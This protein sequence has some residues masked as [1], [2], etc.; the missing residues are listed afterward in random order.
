MGK[1][2]GFHLHPGELAGAADGKEYA[3]LILRSR[4]THAHG[5]Q[6]GREGAGVDGHERI[7][8][9]SQRLGDG[10]NV[11]V[12]HGIAGRHAAALG[13]QGLNAAAHGLRSGQYGFKGYETALQRALL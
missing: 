5:R 7:G 12:G 9:F 6:F 13:A 10:G 8:G 11:L 3:V 4:R 1:V 2:Q